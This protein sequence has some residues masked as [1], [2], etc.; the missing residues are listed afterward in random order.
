VYTAH[1]GAGW[2]VARCPWGLL[3]LASTV[4]PILRPL[5]MDGVGFHEAFFAPGSYGDGSRTPLKRLRDPTAFDCGVGRALW[6]M[7][8]ARPSLVGETIARYAPPRRAALWSGIG[9]AATY[10][11]GAADADLHELVCASGEHR[12]ALAVGAAFA[13]KARVRAENP[14]ADAARACEV[15]CEATLE[16]AAAVTDACLARVRDTAPGDAYWRWRALIEAELMTRSRP[17][18]APRHRATAGVAGPLCGT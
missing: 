18:P 15:L 3:T 6:F 2:A 8:G 14:T 13:A 5:V 9:L 16:A 12:G 4:E 7:A 11:G 17:A 1:V 10:A